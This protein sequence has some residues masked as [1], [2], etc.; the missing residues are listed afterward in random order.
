[1]FYFGL[2]CHWLREL[3]NIYWKTR[4]S[5]RSKV[6][7]EMFKRHYDAVTKTLPLRHARYFHFSWQIPK[8]NSTAVKRYQKVNTSLFIFI[9]CQDPVPVRRRTLTAFTGKSLRSCGMRPF[10]FSKDAN[11]LFLKKKLPPQLTLKLKTTARCVPL[12]T[13]LNSPWRRTKGKVV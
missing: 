13:Q 12:C 7:D 4:T 6:G 1:M 8:W 2:L 3:I 10:F 9:Y 5:L 11:L